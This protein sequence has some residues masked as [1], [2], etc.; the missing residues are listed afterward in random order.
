[1]STEEN[2]AVEVAILYAQ[3]HAR[4]MQIEL[5]NASTRNDH[6]RWSI[7]TADADRLVTVLESIRDTEKVTVDKPPSYYVDWDLHTT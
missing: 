2:G 6:I 5:A 1:M 7:L 4:A 3:A